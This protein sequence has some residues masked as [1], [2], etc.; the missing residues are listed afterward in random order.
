MSLTKFFSFS[1]LL[2]DSFKIDWWSRPLIKERMENGALEEKM[3]Q[4]LA[5]PEN[6]LNGYRKWSYIMI[7]FETSERILRNYIKNPVKDSLLMTAQFRLV[8]DVN[9]CM[10]CIYRD[11]LKII[12]IVIV[13]MNM[14]I[15]VWYFCIWS[16]NFWHTAII[17]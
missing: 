9:L 7:I 15:K 4:R 2:K 1:N 14:L 3:R 8:E 11:W 16:Y 12:C 17:S 6:T 10:K 5:L 13:L